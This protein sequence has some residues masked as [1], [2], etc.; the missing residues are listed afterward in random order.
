MQSLGLWKTARLVLRV[1]MDVIKNAMLSVYVL[2]DLSFSVKYQ[3][4][5]GRWLYFAVFEQIVHC[6]SKAV[7]VSV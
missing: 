4:T 7:T 2:L 6:S 1:K 3:C 5:N